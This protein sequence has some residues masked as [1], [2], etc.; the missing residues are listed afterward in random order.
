MV[1]RN[2]RT[3]KYETR[4]SVS[5][6]VSNECPICLLKFVD[7]E[8]VRRLPCFHLFHT[9][10]VDKWLLDQKEVCPNCRMNINSTADYLSE[11]AL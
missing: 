6:D 2:T 4:A 8:D 3:F 1:E 11:S 10:C 7:Q 9:E 5:D